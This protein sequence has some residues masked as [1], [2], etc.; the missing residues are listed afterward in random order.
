MFIDKP[1]TVSEGEALEFM[2]AL[3]AHG[4]QISGG[5][6]LKQDEG[7]QLLRRESEE[8][9]HGETLGGYVRAPYQRE[10]A[11]G[12]FFF[13]A[14]HLVEGVCEVFGR[15]PKS[16]IA[17]KND[18]RVNVIFKYD[19]FEV[20]GVFIEGNYVYNVTRFSEEKSSGGDLI[21]NVPG[22]V[23]SLME[24][25]EVYELMSGA[26]S[27]ISYED[28]ISPVFIMNAIE[29]ALASGKEEAVGKPTV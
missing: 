1:I 25:E 14:Q 8:K 6:S 20:Y 27:S 18:D 16:V 24:A 26:E 19:G 2:R 17:D 7:V 5:S 10:N 9:A 11:Y 23:W 13:Y 12:G 29:R 21:R 22:N 15:Y 28:F 4:T 3:K